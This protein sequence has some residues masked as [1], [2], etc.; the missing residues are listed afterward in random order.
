MERKQAQD[1]PQELLDILDTRAGKQHSRT[2]PVVA[3]LVEILNVAFH[4][5][6]EFIQAHDAWDKS[7]FSH[8]RDAHNR[9]VA[10]LEAARAAL[11]DKNG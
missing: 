6:E 8:D 4:E 3:A 10:R 11:G 1:F 2:G 5:Y 9:N 7:F